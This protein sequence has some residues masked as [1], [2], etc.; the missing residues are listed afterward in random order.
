MNRAIQYRIYPSEEQKQLFAKTFGCCRKTEEQKQLF[1]KTFG[2]CRKIWN[3]MLA[4]REAA[5]QKDKTVIKPTPAMYKNE[6]PYL[7]EVDSLA[8]ANVQLDLQEAYHRFF[9]VKGTGHPKFKSRKRSRNSYTTNNQ[10][11]TRTQYDP[12]SKDW[13]GKSKT[14]SAS[15]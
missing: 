14:A 4:D 5:Y 1:A 7:K 2:C 9:T 6:Y 10:N 12:S 15:V 8:L 11:G 3:L 13:T